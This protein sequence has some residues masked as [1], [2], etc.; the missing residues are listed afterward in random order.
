MIDLEIYDFLEKTVKGKEEDL[1]KF[2]KMCECDEETGKLGVNSLQSIVRN[3]VIE[4]QQDDP[5]YTRVVYRKG[6]YESIKLG[7]IKFDILHVISLLSKV[8]EIMEKDKW[9]I[10]MAVLSVLQE[11][12]KMDVKLSPA[13]GIIVSVLYRN[14]YQKRRGRMIEEEKLKEL[15]KEEF[16]ANLRN[17]EFDDEFSSAINGLY[18]LKVIEI[19]EGKVTLIEEV[20]V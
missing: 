12:K 10:F 19:S 15:V 18:K 16:E 17:A 8:P 20:T 5:A 13:M 6:G 9:A 1:T 3:S 11:L 14:D 2:Q 4:E 7:N